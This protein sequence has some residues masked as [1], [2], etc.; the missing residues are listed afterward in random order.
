MEIF[1]ESYHGS[2]IEKYFA[3]KSGGFEP[4]SRVVEGAA[5]GLFLCFTNRC[6][7]TLVAA[8]ASALGYCGKPNDHLNYEFFNSDFVVEY[9][10]K[11]SISTLQQYVEAIY[12][13]F[14]SLLKIFFTKGSLDQLMWLRRCGVIGV[15]FPVY[16]YLQVVRRDLV[17][18]AVSFVIAEQTGQ[19]TTMHRPYTGD[20]FYDQGRVANAISY[21]S[22]MTA[23][24]NIYFSLL[25]VQPAYFSYEEVLVD[26]SQVGEKLKALTA[27]DALPRRSR[28]L[29]VGRQS[30]NL[31]LEWCQ[32]FRAEVSMGR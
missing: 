28:T 9:S 2:E 8:E 32:R 21:F 4:I 16:H 6:G 11:N 3:R 15:A 5:C 10:E 30:Q 19:W 17:A 18:Q 26:L 7:S 23:D 25:D 24:A 13:E 1:S 31:N 20:L 12:E 22:K 29:D 14:G 27:I